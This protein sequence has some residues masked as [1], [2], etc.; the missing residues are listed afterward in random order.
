MSTENSGTHS[1]KSTA[2][3]PS[4]AFTS[5]ADD[6]A[7]EPDWTDQVTDLV[8]DT[9]DSIRSKTT[10][11]I[12]NAVR[13]SVYG[14]VALIVLIPILI[15]FF[16]GLVKFLNWAVPGDVWISYLIIATVMWLAGWFMWTRRRP[17]T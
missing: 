6:S 10:G 16:A 7:N 3:D 9:V 11:P 12:Q 13:A 17:V 1:S 4:A 8:V 2:S 14:L 5:P 15:A